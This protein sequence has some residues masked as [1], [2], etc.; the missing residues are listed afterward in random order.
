MLLLVAGCPAAPDLVDD[1]YLNL[2]DWSS[3]NQVCTLR[4]KLTPQ[5]ATCCATTHKVIFWA[6]LTLPR[7][8]VLP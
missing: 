5:Q 8:L 4:E 1:Y 6:L 3:G 2:L 7:T